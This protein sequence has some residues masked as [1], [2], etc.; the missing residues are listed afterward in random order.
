MEKSDIRVSIKTM[1]IMVKEKRYMKMEIIIL[2]YGM[3]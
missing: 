1:N 3:G 2:D